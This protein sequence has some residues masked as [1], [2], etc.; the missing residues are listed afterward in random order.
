[1]KKFQT[2]LDACLLVIV[3]C[4]LVPVSLFLLLAISTWIGRLKKPKIH[5]VTSPLE[6]EVVH[7]L[8]Q[9]FDLLKD[10][11]SCQPGAV[12]YAPDVFPAIIHSFEP[13]VTTYDDVQEKLGRYLY[14]REPTTTL[15]DGS[16]YFV[17]AYDFRGDRVFTIGFLFGGDGVLQRILP[18][19]YDD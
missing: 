5:E 11:S 18:A 8:C 4:V 1:M 9:K 13:G 3:V 12:V 16:T 10:D 19:V 6:A 15:A 14:E 17:S 2:P 7:D